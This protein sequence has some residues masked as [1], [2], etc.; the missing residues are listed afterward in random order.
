MKVDLEK[1]FSILNLMGLFT[2]FI[3]FSRLETTMLAVNRSNLGLSVFV[4]ILEN[5]NHPYA[6]TEVYFD[7]GHDQYDFEIEKRTVNLCEFFRNNHYEPPLHTFGEWTL[8]NGM[9]DTE[10]FF[11]K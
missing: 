6:Y 8:A 1:N 3:I 9:P 11:F 7:S 4:Q 2:V 5:I 10:G